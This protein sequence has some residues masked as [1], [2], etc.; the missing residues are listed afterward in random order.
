IVF[1]ISMVL[2]V[3]LLNLFDLNQFTYEGNILKEGEGITKLVHRFSG[4][5]IIFLNIILFNTLYL[6]GWEKFHIVRGDIMVAIKFY[7]VLVILIIF[8]RSI[9]SITSETKII[10]LSYKM[11]VPLSIFNLLFTVAF[12]VLR[13]IYSLI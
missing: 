13:N 6:G 2:Q 9:S 8:E 3:K 7:I 11:L 5:L 4:Y 12:Y 1:F 10:N